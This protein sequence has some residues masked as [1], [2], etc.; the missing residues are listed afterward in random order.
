MNIKDLTE[1]D[2]NRKVIYSSFNSKEVGVISSWNDKYIFVRY[3]NKT[4][5]E[6]T[7]PNDLEYELN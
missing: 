1:K 5:G 6:A 4:F 2:V 7:D 3:G